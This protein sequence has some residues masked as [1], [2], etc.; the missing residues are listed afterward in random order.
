MPLDSGLVLGRSAMTKHHGYQKVAIGNL[1]L[2]NGRGI[3]V[4]LTNAEMAQQVKIG[5]S[6]GRQLRFT[7]P[8]R[9]RSQVKHFMQSSG[10][11]L[12][13]P[14]DTLPIADEKIRAEI[15]HRS[16]DNPEFWTFRTGAARACAN[17]YVQYPAM[18]VP[19]MQRELVDVITSC[20]DGVRYLVDP[21]VG[22]GTV[23]AEAMLKGL[24]VV[25]QD[26]NPLAVLASKVRTG[27]FLPPEKL[28][29]RFE[30]VIQRACGDGTTQ[31]ETSLGAVD[32][33]FTKA[34]SLDLSRLRRAIR[35]EHNRWVR[36]F[37]W[38]TLAET[39]RQTSNS[40]P[41]T[42]KLH[43]RTEADIAALPRPIYVFPIVGRKNVQ[44]YSAWYRDLT[45][46]GR[47]LS[48]RYRG[49]ARA[50]LGDSVKRLPKVPRRD[51]AKGY[52]LMVTSPPYGD[53]LSTVTYGQFSYLPLW[54]IDAEDIQPGL[55][56]DQYLVSTQEIDRRSLGGRR[57]SNP[58]TADCGVVEK[59][60]SLQRILQH[61]PKD[62]P[63]RAARVLAF[64]RD[65]DRS[66]A[67]IV[68]SLRVNAYMVW[69]VGNRKVGGVEVPTSSILVE[70]LEHLGV[71]QVHE[72]TR[73]IVSK[74]MAHRNGISPTMKAEHVLILRRGRLN[75]GE[76]RV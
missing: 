12:P 28:L 17:S 65:L 54:W 9:L 18:M 33:W 53:N 10:T 14:F 27:A 34:A 70:L 39:I 63:D 55:G 37:M 30:G 64:C 38:V 3:S 23:I 68:R 29:D 41:S 62:K 76:C 42:F 75:R 20:Q 21:F 56:L 7:M 74:R 46:S 73:P 67:P 48:T 59:S 61:M 36:R 32:K 4:K 15:E 72:I 69:T 19:Q 47:L 13:A 45:G 25:G 50:A 71:V 52:D 60:P 31:L 6:S 8:P 51:G 22:A 44:N 57:V 58:S 24:D 16:K 49:I 2:G 26:I 40:R 11:L 5:P 66:L 35:L 43:T 1:V